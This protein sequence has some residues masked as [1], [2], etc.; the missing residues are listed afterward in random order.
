MYVLKGDLMYQH[1][2]GKA[3]IGFASYLVGSGLMTIGEF[4]RAISRVEDLTIEQP[5]WLSSSF[6]NLLMTYDDD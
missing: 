3:I 4:V 2:D 5:D 6:I 1:A